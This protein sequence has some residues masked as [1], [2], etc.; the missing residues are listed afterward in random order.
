MKLSQKEFDRIVKRAIGRISPE[1]R[2]HL[3]NVVI[4]VRERPTRKMLREMGLQPD[5]LLL[6]VYRGVS[7]IRRS[8]TSP[9][10][11]PDTIILFQEPLEETCQTKEKLEKQI[12]ITMVHEVAHF[13]GISEE[14]LEELGYG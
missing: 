10:L 5:E 13:V 1:I 12:E 9:P 3:K 8:V 7:L 2:Q 11:F 4:S 14:R 6:G